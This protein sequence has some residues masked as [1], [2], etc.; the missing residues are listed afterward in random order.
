MNEDKLN[1]STR[2]LLKNVGINSQ[3]IIENNIRSAVESGKIKSDKKIKVLISVKIEELN[4][5]EN[6]EGDIE[7]EL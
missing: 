1:L 2:R 4:I 7:V 3:R 5:N 6:I